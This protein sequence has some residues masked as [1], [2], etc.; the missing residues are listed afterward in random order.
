MIEKEVEIT[1]YA[2]ATGTV[3]PFIKEQGPTY[4]SGGQPAEG[5][6]CEDVQVKMRSTDGKTELDI[7]HMLSK[8]EIEGLGEEL[9][10]KAKVESRDVYL[11]DENEE[12]N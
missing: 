12:D 9:Y 7:T 1:L 8:E 3:V 10:E 5:G 6:Y 2:F 4:D 11:W